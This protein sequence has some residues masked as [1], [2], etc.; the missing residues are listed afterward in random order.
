M[1]I[2]Q[3]VPDCRA[4]MIKSLAAVRAKSAARNS[5]MIQG[6]PASEAHHLILSSIH[7]RSFCFNIKLFGCWAAGLLH[8][9]GYAYVHT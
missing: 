8:P 4:S 9:L 6:H 1:F 3:R 2:W 7:D 5:A